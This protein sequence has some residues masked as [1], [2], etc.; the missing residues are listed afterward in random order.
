MTTAE[1]EAWVEAERAAAPR[2]ARSWLALLVGGAAV[3]QAGLLLLRGYLGL[4]LGLLGGAAVLAG[5]LGFDRMAGHSVHWSVRR[6]R[7]RSPDEREI[8]QACG[9]GRE[10]D[11]YTPE[12]RREDAAQQ[13]EPA[14]C[15]QR[16]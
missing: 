15:A 16:A 8:L 6:G 12:E 4:G 14:E 13:R 5:A 2:K 1:M 11:P 9:L 3:Q 10:N 7:V